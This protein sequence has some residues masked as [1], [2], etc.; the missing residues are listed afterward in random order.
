MTQN[1]WLP[2]LRPEYLVGLEQ[3]RIRC[4]RAG[5]GSSPF[6]CIA[7]PE[8]GAGLVRR[9]AG[10]EVI[11]GGGGPEVMIFQLYFSGPL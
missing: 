6:L 9:L 2:W 4:H 3:A 7:E 11:V 10:V 5:T 1:V 8:G